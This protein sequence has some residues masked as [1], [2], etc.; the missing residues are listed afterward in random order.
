[1]YSRFSVIASL[2]STATGRENAGVNSL[3]SRQIDPLEETLENPE[4]PPIVMGRIDG[5]LPASTPARRGHRIAFLIGTFAVVMTL[6]GLHL[7][8]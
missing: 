4:L 5:P 6:L 2:C 3:P 8:R 7:A 1:L